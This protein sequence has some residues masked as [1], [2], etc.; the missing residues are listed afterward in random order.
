[1]ESPDTNATPQKKWESMN[2]DQELKAM[3]EWVN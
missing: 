1:M 2:I 3:L